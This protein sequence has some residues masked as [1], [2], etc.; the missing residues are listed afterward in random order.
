[1]QVAYEL[2]PD[3]KESDFECARS[4]QENTSRPHPPERALLLA[5]LPGEAL[6]FLKDSPSFPQLREPASVP[7]GSRELWEKHSTLGGAGMTQGTG[8]GAVGGEAAPQEGD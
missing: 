8:C 2:I 7:G 6:P 4:C 5:L 3:K 1:M